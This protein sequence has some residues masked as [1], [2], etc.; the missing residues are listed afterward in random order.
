MRYP[1][2]FL[3]HCLFWGAVVVVK[4]FWVT[5]DLGFVVHG[6][7]Y[8]GGAWQLFSSGKSQNHDKTT[9]ASPPTTSC[10]SGRVVRLAVR[11]FHPQHSRPS[12][13]GYTTRK[14]SVSK[15]H[16]TKA[17]LQDDY[18]HYRS[19]ALGNTKDRA[20]SLWTTDCLDWVRQDV[21]GDV[22]PGD[23]GENV[24]IDGLDFDALVVGQSYRFV[25]TKKTNNGISTTD[26]GVVIQITEPVV[27]CASLC[28]LPCI[29]RDDKTPKERIAACQ[30]FLEKLDQAPGLRGWYAKVLQEGTIQLNDTIR[31]NV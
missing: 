18:N 16:V 30:S 8:H 21:C 17:G 5:P 20:I 2:S 25:S 13:H 22:Q 23:L 15:A 1:A 14:D 12:S 19:V 24:L 29:N 28:K 31:E 26:S 7:R 9:V 11:S 4:A 27:P 6:D 3:I 10:S